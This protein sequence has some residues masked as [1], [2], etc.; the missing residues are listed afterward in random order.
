[1]FDTAGSVK[2]GRTLEFIVTQVWQASRLVQLQHG[3][4]K[5]RKMR[6]A[7]SPG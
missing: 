2:D 3:S 6:Y 7:G 5:E 4:G 1:M